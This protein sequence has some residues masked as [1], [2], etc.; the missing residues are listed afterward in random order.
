M[1][2]GIMSSA[3][4]VEASVAL[5]QQLASHTPQNLDELSELA[6]HMRT[7]FGG[8]PD[9]GTLLDDMLKRLTEGCELLR[10]RPPEAGSDA[11]AA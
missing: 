11:I 1:P 10:S 3:V 7:V 5:S 8:P 6:R 9:E 2:W 4:G